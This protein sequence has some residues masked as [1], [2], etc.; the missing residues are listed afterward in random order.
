MLLP[1]RPLLLLWW[2][3]FRGRARALLR[4]TRTIGGALSVLV[5]FLLILMWVGS[6]ALRSQTLERTSALPSVDVV[7]LGLLGYVVFVSFSSISLRGVYLPR[8]ELER[9]FAAPIARSSLVRYRMLVTLFQTLPFAALMA[10]LLAPRLPSFTVTLCAFLIFAPTASFF[11]QG[12]SLLS[13][14]TG[15][16]LDRTFSRISPSLMRVVGSVGAASIFLL[17]AFGP[18]LETPDSRERAEREQFMEEFWGG[19]ADTARRTEPTELFDMAS[20]GERLELVATHPVTR[21]VT[22]PLRPWARAVS[23]PDMRTAAP[24]L[25]LSLMLMALLHAAVA[26]LPIDFRESSLRSSMAVE[27]RLNRVRQGQGGVGVFGTS[28]RARGWSVPWLMGRTGFGAIVWLRTSMLVRQARGTLFVVSAVAILGIVLGTR[29]LTEPVSG[30]AVVAVLGVV[31]LGSGMRVDFRADLDRM[32]ALKAWP[33]PA[34]TTFVA[35]VIPGTLLTSCVVLLVLLARAAILDQFTPD[36]TWYAI[37]TPVV[38]Y[39]W[40]ALDNA[41]FLLFPVRFVPGQGSAIQHM[42]R[43]FMLVMFRGLLLF[44]ALAF[45]GGGAA[46]IHYLVL[47]DDPARAAA[48]ASLAIAWGVAVSLGLL[49][50]VT[51]FGGWALRRFDVSK[52]PGGTA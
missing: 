21:V 36:L 9:L 13:A 40:L 44:G 47:D 6:I 33:L 37:G 31:Y 39:V 3:K 26:R 52:T 5:G 17:L 24:W 22:A 49:L 14:R 23:A 50:A 8:P 16:R 7:N 4:R 46:L 12:L 27:K 10:V 34:R 51:S 29:V 43:G 1:E 32:D 19:G 35:T 2:L 41:V 11:G 18:G 38:A 48:A 15:G 28:R 45:A 42:G 25:A 20:L 30:T